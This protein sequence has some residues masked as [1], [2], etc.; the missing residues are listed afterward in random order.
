MAW[1]RM[2]FQILG[3]RSS[4][5]RPLDHCMASGGSTSTWSKSAYLPQRA[6]HAAHWMP[7]HGVVEC[8]KELN[9]KKWPI[10]APATA[11]MVRTW[12]IFPGICYSCLATCQ[13]CM[14]FQPMILVRAARLLQRAKLAPDN[15]LVPTHQKS[16][17]HAT[18]NAPKFTSSLLKV[19]K[20]TPLLLFLSNT[21]TACRIVSHQAV[22]CTRPRGPWN[23]MQGEGTLELPVS[24]FKTVPL[25]C[26]FLHIA[27]A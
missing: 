26:Y 7:K 11:T 25:K 23:L 14:T 19:T 16:N 10:V 21:Q 22:S 5:K 27:L 8:G 3:S 4:S 24:G 12:E 17:S 15:L 18:A 2:C 6:P 1:Q 20:S 13:C 9:M